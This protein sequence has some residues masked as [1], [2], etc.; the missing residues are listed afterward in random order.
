[1]PALFIPCQIWIGQGEP[2]QFSL[3]HGHVDK[4]LAELVVGKPL[5]VPFHALGRIGRLVV[6][7]PKHHQ[8]RPPP[9]VQG[10]L[11]HGFLVVRS[12]RKAVHDLEPLSLVK[13]FFFADAHH[14]PG[15][16]PIAALA[17]RHLVHDG[18]PVDEPAY[19]AHVR[20]SQGGIVEDGAVFG[21]A[22]MQVVQHFFPGHAQRLGGRVEV[23]P[24]PCFIL[25]LGQKNGFALQG[26]RPG[27]PIA[28]GQH[29]NNF[30]VG[31]LA[32]LPNQ[33]LAVSIGHPIFGLDLLLFCNVGFKACLQVHFYR[34]HAR[35]FFSKLRRVP[36]LK[37]TDLHNVPKPRCGL[38]S[39]HG[40]IS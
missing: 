37:A 34:T 36:P 23:E 6:T 3:R 20:P 15:I 22:Y 29:A 12:L 8:G 35:M 9:S 21:L 30:T 26:R 28:F 38:L 4:P 31:M 5:D 2:E 10:I 24:V 19:C 25:H 14:R 40:E 33:R 16:R 32:D 39:C 27:N 17:Q 1:M 13:A 18:R 11:G 7:R